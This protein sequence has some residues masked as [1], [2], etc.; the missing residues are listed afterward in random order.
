MLRSEMSSSL[1]ARIVLLLVV[2]LVASSSASAGEAPKCSDEPNIKTA[3]S[4][5]E[6]QRNVWTPIGWKDHLFR[7]DVVYNGHLLCAPA[8]RLDKPH[9]QK[10]KGQDFQ[11]NFYPSPD[12]K[13]P[14]MPHDGTKLKLTDG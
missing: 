10:Y 9:I 12:G 5:W 8:G 4:W 13:L 3:L 14:P 1:Y 2:A 7:F 6:P 11:L